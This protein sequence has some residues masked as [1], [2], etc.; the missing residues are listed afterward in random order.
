[1]YWTCHKVSKINGK[2]LNIITCTSDIFFTYSA[3][4][5]KLINALFLSNKCIW[6]YF[7]PWQ[8]SS[9]VKFN[10]KDYILCIY[11]ASLWLHIIFVSIYISSCVKIKLLYCVWIGNTI[12]V[13]CLSVSHMHRRM[14]QASLIRLKEE[15][16]WWLTQHFEAMLQKNSRQTCFSKF[17]CALAALIWNEHIL[18]FRMKEHFSSS[19]FAMVSYYF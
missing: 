19:T 2:C 1:M 4:V 9:V 17:W 8:W 15:P 16:Y 14:V 7:M 13:S 5:C 10:K 12:L 18:F 3:F 6:I 11:S